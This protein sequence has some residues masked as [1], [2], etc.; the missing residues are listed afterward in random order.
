MFAKT[1]LVLPAIVSLASAVDWPVTVGANGAFSFN[2]TTVTAAA[3]DTVSFQF[4]GPHSSTQSTF[5]SP[6]SPMSGGFD[7]GIMSPGGTFVV[8]VNDTTTPIWVYCQVPGHCQ[9]GMVFAVNAPASGNTYA[10]FVDAAEGKAAPAPAAGSSST[11]AGSSS[12]A[13]AAATTAAS[14]SNN[15]YGGTS[16]SSGASALKVSSALAGIV[17]IAGLALLL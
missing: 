13:A 14:T 17:G 15:P 8:T 4:Q 5:G 16:S 6:C 1:L 2:P 11:P 9:S 10:A 12:S 7:S 3:L